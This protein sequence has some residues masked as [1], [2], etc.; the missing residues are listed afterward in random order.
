[1]AC[2][3]QGRCTGRACEN[4]RRDEGEDGA[5]GEGRQGRRD[6]R[7]RGRRDGV[8]RPTR[9]P[10]TTERKGGRRRAGAWSWTT[11]DAVLALTGARNAGGQHA[12]DSARTV[13]VR[14]AKGPGLARPGTSGTGTRAWHGHRILCT[15]TALRW[16]RAS[17]SSTCQPA[18]L[19]LLALCCCIRRAARDGRRSIDGQTG[20][21]G[22][23]P[24]IC[25]DG[26][27]RRQTAQT[28]AHGRTGADGGKLPPRRRHKHL[29]MLARPWPGKGPGEGPGEEPGE[30]PGSTSYVREYKVHVYVLH[31]VERGVGS[32]F[33]ALHGRT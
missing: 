1:M 9:T 18:C 26:D 23:R 33:S 5:E 20:R 14:R 19:W 24:C 3:G 30:E 13:S 29:A 12:G 25:A 10:R 4:R 7:G 17:R 16:R 32:T 8:R 28:G 15:N 6:A 11:N 31:A 21:V 2:G 27:R 22:G